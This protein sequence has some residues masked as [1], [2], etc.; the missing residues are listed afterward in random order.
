MDAAVGSPDEIPRLSGVEAREKLVRDADRVVRV[1]AGNGSVRLRIPVRVVRLD[2][3]LFVA[4]LGVVERVLDVR[5]R[6]S[7]A[8]R[9]T[10]RGLQPGVVRW[11][12]AR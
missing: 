6:D 12:E 4:L 10:H 5:R 11:V 1:L 7:G 8:Q 3:Q 2:L 9:R